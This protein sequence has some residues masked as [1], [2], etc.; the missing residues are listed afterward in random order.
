VNT[1]VYKTQNS[2]TLPINLAGREVKTYNPYAQKGG[3]TM[4]DRENRRLQ[5]FIRA[6]DFGVAH[7]SDFTD[8]SL[9]RQLVATLTTTITEIENHAAA[10]V[11]GKGQARQGSATRSMAREA[12]RED[13]EAINRTADAMGADVP[14]LEGKFELPPVNDQLLLNAARAFVTDAAPLRGQFV[15]H[16]LPADFLDVL[17]ADIVALETA[18][19]EQASGVGDHVA[20]GASIDDAMGR[21]NDAVRKLDAIVQNRYVNNPGVLAEWAS[22][23]HT[24]RA[25]QRKA[26]I[27]PQPPTP[28]ADAGSTPPPA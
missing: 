7:S 12:L 8:G 16:E 13:L 27:T 14:G 6:R 18:I 20:A 3:F 26:P 19:S 22:A 23:S 2:T 1:V 4:N 21:G 28:S 5:M 11:S 10:E 24:E 15:A 17:N 25:P 9:G